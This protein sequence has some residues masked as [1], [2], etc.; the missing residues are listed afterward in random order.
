MKY[1]IRPAGCVAWATTTGKKKAV[2][3]YREARQFSGRVYIIDGAGKDVT[4]EL[5]DEECE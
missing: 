4:L 2:S 1:T 5:I 3:L